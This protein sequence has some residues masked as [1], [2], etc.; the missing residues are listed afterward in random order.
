M[1]TYKTS[2]I[3]LYQATPSSNWELLPHKLFIVDDIES[4]L[5]TKTF[6]TYTLVQY[7]KPTLELSI[8]LDL[9][10][11]YAEPL[12]SGFKYARIE[13]SDDTG[14]YYY[15]FVKS[16]DW[17]AKSAVRFNL[18]MDVLNTFKEGTHYT[19]KDSTKISREHK[20]RF[21]IGGNIEV[22]IYQEFLSGTGTLNIGDTVTL[23]DD[24]NTTLLHGTIEDYDQDYITI[25]D[26]TGHTSEEMA[27]LFESSEKPYCVKKDAAN[28][29]W[30]DPSSYNISSGRVWRKIDYVPENI[31]P[32]LQCGDAEG[33]KVEFTN[34]TLRDD[35][36]LLYRNEND[37]TDS[38]VNPV[39]C[40]LIPK[41]TTVISTGGLTS[42]Q[43][44]PATLESGKLYYFP[45]YSRNIVDS[46]V[47]IPAY[48]QSISAS[49]GI[50][51]SGHDFTD[52]VSY[53]VVAKTENGL[54]NVLYNKLVYNG[55]GGFTVSSQVIYGTIAHLTINQS[56]TYYNA[57]ATS[58][59]TVI[60]IYC[61]LLSTLARKTFT[62][63]QTGESLDSIDEL[64]RTQ[65]K[66][67]KL[68]KLPYVPYQFTTSGSRIDISNSD[69]NLEVI[70][71]PNANT[72]NFNALKLNDLNTELKSEWIN[73]LYKPNSN[74]YINTLANINPQN[75]DLR[76]G[77]SYE[78]KLFNSEFYR[79]TFYYDSFQFIVQLEKCDLSWYMA[80]LSRTSH[81]KIIFNVT[82]TINSK[83]MFTFDEYHIKNG[84]ENYA[85]YMPIARNNEEVLYNVP[86]INYIRTGYNYD[87]KQKNRSNV[88]NW[89]SV[90]GSG[91]GLAAS[92]VLPSAPLKALGIVTSL[93]SMAMTVKNAVV[94]TMNNQESID[95]KLKEAEMQTASVSGS[96]DVD[97][98]SVYAE[99]RLKYLVYEPNDIMKTMLYNLF[100]FAGYNSQRMGL[101]NHNTRLNFDYL[102]C[103]A[104]INKTANIPD[105]CLSELI[106]SFKNGVTYIHK[107]NRTTD[108]WDFEQKYEN[109]EKSLGVE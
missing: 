85:K 55:N 98:M 38:L 63:S 5:A 32:V 102:E 6:N 62:T 15:Y 24:V 93:I 12:N 26:D 91:V 72:V 33:S 61:D 99:N 1:G 18:V 28:Y 109:W 25:K 23:L 36:Y 97:L 80:D 81:F 47:D 46:Y 21:I 34:T 16:I 8:V 104:V 87:I 41:T 66:N 13:N 19:F 103:D 2:T 101:P 96:D 29:A 68:I 77:A 48:N 60:Q 58:G 11:T 39:E 82:K 108:K 56:P 75:T 64:D 84:S 54:L 100:F 9:S 53:L 52:E 107:T 70:N 49:N 40:Y 59:L 105:D 14:H 17:R 4:Y 51:F 94:T 69:W 7:Q 78:S 89:L 31:N 86:Y 73:Y 42:G 83:F 76:K 45:I 90:A 74:L 37:P 10:Q 35:W 43:I 67:I 65:A 88:S 3:R 79:P 27:A 95:R 71:Q 22:T 50:T 44:T 20:D 30:Y 57:S 92:L 106:N